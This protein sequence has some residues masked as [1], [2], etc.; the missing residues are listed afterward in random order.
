L[1]VISKEINEVKED[2]GGFTSAPSE[3]ETSAEEPG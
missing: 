2:E 1:L 3:R